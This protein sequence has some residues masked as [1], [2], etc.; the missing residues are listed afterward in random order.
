[1]IFSPELKVPEVINLGRKGG[2]GGLL[3]TANWLQ[4]SSARLPRLLLNIYPA[5]FSAPNVP[6]LR[7]RRLRPDEAQ[8]L[9]APISTKPLDSRRFPTAG[10]KADGFEPGIQPRIGAVIGVQEAAAG[11]KMDFGPFP[12]CLQRPPPGGGLNA[13]NRGRLA[14]LMHANYGFE[15]R[16]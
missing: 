4:R 9:T 3:R 13:P 14:R 12:A 11:L 10:A 5:Y 7:D 15:R 8:T 6:R 1:M 16:M 2:N